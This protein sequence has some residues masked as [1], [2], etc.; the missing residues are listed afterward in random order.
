MVFGDGDGEIFQRFTRSLDVIGH[1]LAHGVTESEAGLI[2]A[3]QSGALN[4]SLS[5][6]FGVLTKQYSLGQTAEQADWLIGA[7]LLMPKIQEAN[8]WSSRRECRWRTAATKD[9]Y[10]TACSEVN[11]SVTT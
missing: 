10:V 6:V 7:D 9:S 5:D 3:N 11:P 1:E 4:E 8:L 2:Y